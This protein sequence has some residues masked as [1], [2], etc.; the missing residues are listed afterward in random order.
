MSRI[1]NFSV[2]LTRDE[3][4]AIYQGRI[5]T[6]MVLSDTGLRI[7]MNATHFMSFTTQNGIRGHFRMTLDDNNR[8]VKMVQLD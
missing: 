3:V 8:F 4:L 5:K 7:E 2:S 1:I 6:I